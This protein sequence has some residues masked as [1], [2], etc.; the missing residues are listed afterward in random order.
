MAVTTTFDGKAVVKPFSWSYSR[1]KNYEACPKK[2]YHLDIKKDL[3]PE[4]SEI[5]RAHV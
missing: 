1:L 5:G 2:H 3:P 4:E